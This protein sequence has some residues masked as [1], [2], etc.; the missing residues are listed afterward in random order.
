MLRVARESGKWELMA[1]RLPVVENGWV[2][3]PALEQGGERR[4]GYVKY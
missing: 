2:I 4:H 3:N 1:D